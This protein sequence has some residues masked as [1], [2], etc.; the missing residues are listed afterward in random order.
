MN[1]IIPAHLGRGQFEYSTT[2]KDIT[3]SKSN[4][5]DEVYLT[6]SEKGTYT[7]HS[8]V[9]YCGM[10]CPQIVLSVNAK[11]KYY[12]KFE[13]SQAWSIVAYSE[14]LKVSGTGGGGSETSGVKYVICPHTEGNPP[15]MDLPETG[16]D[17]VIY[18]CK[19]EKGHAR[20]QYMKFMWIDEDWENMGIVYIKGDFEYDSQL[21]TENGT[22]ILNADHVSS[23]R[24]SVIPAITE[25]VHDGEREY[26]E[27]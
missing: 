23:S 21:F 20:N 19:N 24:T 17:G 14:G 6:L 12:L 8:T 22:M 25:A 15:A 13:Q 16:E 7:I 11:Q 3:I 10:V 2:D 18:F 27:N 5:G 4:V 1:I 26:D 9:L